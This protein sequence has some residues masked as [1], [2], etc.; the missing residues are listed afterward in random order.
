VYYY[1]K[2]VNLKKNWGVEQSWNIYELPLDMQKP[3]EIKKNKP[4]RKRG[5]E[6][7]GR[8]DDEEEE[9]EFFDDPFMNAANRNQFGNT[10]LDNRRR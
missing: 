8:N 10:S 1:P 2:K 9:D 4:K 3:A 7:P 6:A 5:E